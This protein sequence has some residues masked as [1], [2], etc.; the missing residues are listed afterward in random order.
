MRKNIGLLGISLIFLMNLIYSPAFGGEECLNLVDIPTAGILGYGEYNLNFRMYSQG[1]ILTRAIFGVVDRF[2]FGFYYDVEQVIGRE[3]A[4]G[5]P[6]QLFVKFRLFNGMGFFPACA[7]GFDGQGYGT[8]NS[9]TNEYSEREDGIYLV[10]SKEVFVPGLEFSVGCN[11]YEFENATIDDDLYLFTGVSYN[12]RNKIIF[13]AEYDNIKTTPQNRFNMGLRLFM[14]PDFSVEISG[15]RIGEESETT[16]RIVR[17]DF[18][19]SF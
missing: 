16:E 15:K 7:L 19:D 10:F 17:I 12:M 6:P 1:S 5:R 11:I 18:I 8:Y 4:R 9:E 2:N 13:L 3:S 14:T